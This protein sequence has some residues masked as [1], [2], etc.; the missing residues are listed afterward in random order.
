MFQLHWD[1]QL[2]WEPCNDIM[3]E[4]KNACCPWRIVIFSEVVKS[5]ND[6]GIVKGLACIVTGNGF[7]FPTNVFIFL[8]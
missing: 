4:K 3:L 6:Q 8:K 1:F 2:H 7:N 5:Y